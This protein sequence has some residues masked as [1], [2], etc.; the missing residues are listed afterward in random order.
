MP[1]FMVG[2]VLSYFG[3]MLLRL[4][5]RFVARDGGSGLEVLGASPG[6]SAF[7]YYLCFSSSTEHGAFRTTAA[8]VLPTMRSNNDLSFE[9][10]PIK[11]RSEPQS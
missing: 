2:F 5:L 6:G 11:I 4:L 8:A 9:C 10:A 7:R 1:T 3:F